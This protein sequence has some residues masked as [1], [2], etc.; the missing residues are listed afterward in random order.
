M[1]TKEISIMEELKTTKRPLSRKIALVFSL[2][3]LLYATIAIVF[4][5]FYS[6]STQIETTKEK[7]LMETRK[8]A[9]EISVAMNQPMLTARALADALANA[10]SINLNREGVIRMAQDTLHSQ[11]SFL[12]FRIAFADNSFDDKDS[13]YMNTSV[14]GSRGRFRVHLI[15][16]KRAD[17]NA[18]IITRKPLH[19]Q[20]NSADNAWYVQPKLYR[21][22]FIYGPFL[23][24]FQEKEIPSL[25]FAYPILKDGRFLGVLGIDYSI[26]FLQDFVSKRDFFEKQYTIS[27][28][29]SDGK[30]SAHSNDPTLILQDL[31]KLSPQ[32]Y[33]EQMRKIREGKNT[34]QESAD[35]LRIYVPLRANDVLDFWQIR[36][37]L[38][39]APIKAKI[40]NNLFIQVLIALLFTLISVIII[41]YY[42]GIQ[43]R[44]LK[45]VAQSAAEISAGNLLDVD[46]EY[47]SSD[48]IGALYRAFQTMKERLKTIVQEIYTSSH[49]IAI[50]SQSLRKT[51]TH[52]SS[53]AGEQAASFEEMTTTVEEVASIIEKNANNL[54]KV[55]QETV[56]MSNEIL[57]TSDVSQMTLDS[58][59]EVYAKIKEITSI[60]SQT[61]ILALNT[62][63]EAARAGAQGK[64]FSVVATE[65]RNLAD[66]SRLLANDI[67][68]LI[69]HSMEMSQTT[70]EKMQD[71]VTIVKN[72]VTLLKENGKRLSSQQNATEQ[73]KT[74]IRALTELTQNNAAISEELAA[75][76]E[77]LESNSSLLEDQMGFFR[78]NK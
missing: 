45:D 6:Y 55:N 49:S 8:I 78:I 22:G 10:K 32:N 16:A 68:K 13:R 61:N 21:A 75:S 40:R 5:G 65:V 36:M 54:Q 31:Q 11:E 27:I 71:L 60:A 53:A 18:E 14:Y 33:Q 34:V 59:E 9:K 41:N 38:P 52:L 37:T 28:L 69:Q 35:E 70:K 76:A 30:I 63:I 4:F 42:T 56:H 15:K 1:Q 64:S 57:K 43:L 58:I 48:E 74:G 77:E 7:S 29:S 23:Q 51:G 66:R 73:L 72:V 2:I 19:V 26:E 25:T 50:S 24:T 47:N 20:E 67:S 17:D 46:K 62:G 3:I 39:Y 12:G 44:P